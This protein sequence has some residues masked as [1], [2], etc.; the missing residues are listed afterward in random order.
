[1]ETVLSSNGILLQDELSSFSLK[2]HRKE[3][4]L[5]P[6]LSAKYHLKSSEQTARKI[7]LPRWQEHLASSNQ[8]TH[9]QLLFSGEKVQKSRGGQGQT[10]HKAGESRVR[11]IWRKTHFQSHGRSSGMGGWSYRNG[12]C[13]SSGVG[14]EAKK[15]SFLKKK[16]KV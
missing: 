13:L 16:K 5:L 2:K 11:P 4:Q 9:H 15:T 1:M 8:P 3:V 12:Q 14:E 7:H 10:T 6:A